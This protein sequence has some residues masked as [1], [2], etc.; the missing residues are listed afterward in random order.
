MRRKNRIFYD[1][2]A[3]RGKVLIEFLLTMA[4]AGI[5]MPFIYSFQQRA[6]ERAENLRVTHQ[7]QTIQNVL[8]R[9]IFENRKKMLTTVG[10]NIIRLKMNDLVEY[11]L[12]E[13]FVKDAGDMYQIR[14]LKTNDVAGG[15]GLQGVIVYS[16]S[17]ITPLRTRE[18]VLLGDDKVGFVD[19]T[20]AYGAFGTWRA[21]IADMGIGTDSGIVQ[22]TSV[23]RDNSLYLWRI[24][25]SDSSDATMLAPINMAGRDINDV[26]FLNSAGMVLND[27]FNANKITTNDVIFSNR[28]TL[29][30]PYN[31][32]T[33]VVSGAL[34]GDSRNIDVS[35]AFNLD[36]IA[37]VSDF[38]A[39]NLWVNNLTLGGLSTESGTA[40]TLHANLSL[41]MTEGRV[42]AL[43]VT[44]GFTGSMTSRLGVKSKIEDPSNPDYYWDVKNGTANFADIMSP[45]L[46]SMAS[47]AV[48]VYSAS[49]TSAAQIFSNV[50]ENKNA[51][52]GDF[53]NAIN[54][55]QNIVRG[56]YQM[57]NLE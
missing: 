5:L 24:P 22:T 34:V 12:D 55:I 52:M 46:S 11:G 27:M 18:I 35:G 28:T 8:E 50:S 49:G 57:L 23:N 47:R 29:S 31:T 39:D 21:D 38:T 32:K 40:S 17:E 26:M 15:A 14:V 1:N 20:R 2:N 9:Y 6:V 53:M 7:M 42:N 13:N 16:N 30:F 36:D 3:S 33:A 51:T 44:V 37:K 43:F 48:R 45:T 10:R 56:K 41:D 4:L 19:G 25:S 54:E